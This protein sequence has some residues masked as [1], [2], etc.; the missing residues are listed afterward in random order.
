MREKIRKQKRKAKSRKEKLKSLR[1]RHTTIN[2]SVPQCFRNFSSYASII[3]AP[4]R[5][6]GKGNGIEILDTLN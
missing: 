2:R 4:P 6:K 5:A 1:N 3:Y